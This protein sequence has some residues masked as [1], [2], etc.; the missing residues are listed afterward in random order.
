MLKALFRWLDG[1]PQFYWLTAAVASLLLAGWIIRGFVRPAAAEHSARREWVFGLLLLAVLLAWRW[2]PL[3]GIEAYNPDE[4]QVIAGALTLQSDPVFWRAV[5]GNT[6]GPLN[7][8]ALLPTHWLGV[9][10]DYF[11]AR[12]TGLL[13]VWGALWSC[14]RLLRLDFGSS[15]AALGILPG[16]FFFATTIDTD[17]LQYSTEHL[18]FFL[19]PL[20]ASLLWQ[21]H[22]Q[23]KTGQAYPL[24]L[25]L[26]AGLIMGLLPWAKLQAAPLAA[27]LAAWGTV[28]ALT[29]TSRPWRARF[30]EVGAL[31]AAALAPGLLI[32]LMVASTGQWP[33]FVSSYIVN[34]LAYVNNGYEVMPAVREFI[35]LCVLTWNFPGFLPAPLLTVTVAGVMLIIQKR[36]P[37][38][39]FI[40]G[41]ITTV[42]AG[43]CVIAPRR[44]YP[45]YLLFLILPLTWWAGAALGELW[46]LA[47]LSWLRWCLGVGFVLMTGAISLRV[48]L[49]DPQP[50]LAGKLESNWRQPHDEAGRLLRG[51]RQPGDSLAIWGWNSHLHVQSGLPQATREGVSS[52]QIDP[53][54]QRDTYYR[55]RFLADMERNSPAFFVDAVGDGAFVYFNRE[56]DAHESFEALRDYVQTHYRLVRDVNYA[57]I[58]VRADRMP[59]DPVP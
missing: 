7:F 36:R 13:L 40:M 22:R 12:L 20:S 26:S 50:V 51:L 43:Y 32:L 21:A 16:L 49:L 24:R 3:F 58:Y 38:S 19:F 25:W 55:P 42:V 27:T 34:N 56:R 59:V 11:N 28:L 8:Y 33:H 6:S 17:F 52:R 31:A 2:P 46:S 18:S 41:A 48:R 5:D 53:S 4:A 44:G 10:Q 29:K 35:R 54:E 47:R 23:G 45:H 14:Y 30:A 1:H 39:L 15:V 37:G 9:P 57:R